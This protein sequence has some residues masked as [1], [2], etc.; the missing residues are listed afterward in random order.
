M[1]RTLLFLSV[2]FLALNSF[3]QTSACGSIVNDTFD[4]AGAIPSEWTEYNTS[5]QVTVDNGQLKLD[6]STDKP[7]VYRTFSSVTDNFSYAFDM[8]ST[9]NYVNC[10]MSLISSTG[11]YL[12]SFTFA[13]SSNTNIQYASTMDA[14]I[15]S[16]YTGALIPSTYTT[17]TLYSLSANVNFT[18]QKV[19][20][21]NNGTLM[22]AEIP[23]LETALDV[24]KIDIQLNYMYNNEGR[25][26]FDN[27]S[28][29]SL[30]ES[31]GTIKW[32]ECW[33]NIV[34]FRYSRR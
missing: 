23:F 14:G 11:K 33:T 2:L 19:D 8:S 1:K 12:A 4:T 15:P 16:G 3:A 24:A 20:F 13:L 25:F 10:N 29:F 32:C 9:R 26:F 31:F 5:G 17:N 28:L 21:Y 27:I 34:S 6:Y 30:R 18:T 22:A 7:A